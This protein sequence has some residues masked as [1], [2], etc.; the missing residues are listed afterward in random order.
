[1]NKQKHRLRRQNKKMSRDRD[2]NDEGVE[3]LNDF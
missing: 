3:L 1:M 2:Y